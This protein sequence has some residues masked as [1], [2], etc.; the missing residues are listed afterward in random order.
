M[1]PDALHAGDNVR[2]RQYF[3]IIR[4][5]KNPVTY[6]CLPCEECFETNP[7]IPDI[8]MTMLAQ[9]PTCLKHQQQYSTGAGDGDVWMVGGIM[10]KIIHENLRFL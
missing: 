4:N 5:I 2:L 8:C 7:G 1:G 6:F 10:E 9:I 3:C